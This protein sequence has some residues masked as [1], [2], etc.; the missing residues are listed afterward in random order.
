MWISLVEVRQKRIVS[1]VEQ[2]GG[3]VCHDVGVAW[4]EEATGAVAMESLMGAGLGAEQG[5]GSRLRDGAL[6]MAAERGCVVRSVFD[7]TVRQVEVGAHYAEL[8]LACGLFEV[9]VGHRARGVGHGYEVSADV[10]W[11]LISP[12]IGLE[13]FVVEDPP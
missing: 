6:L 10:G 1:K 2:A 9:A 13:V 5:C 7:S 3:V 11:E 8:S 12:D 4:D